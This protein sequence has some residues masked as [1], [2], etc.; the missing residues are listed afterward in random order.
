MFIQTK[1]LVNLE[2]Q[3]TI[4][5]VKNRLQ[6]IRH[7]V[8]FRLLKGLRKA[9]FFMLIADLLLRHGPL[10]LIRKIRSDISSTYT[11]HKNKATGIHIAGYLR[12]ILGTGEAARLFAGMIKNS[13]IPFTLINLPAGFHPRLSRKESLQ[14][15]FHLS[16]KIFF[17]T[18]L[19]FANANLLNDIFML[20]PEFK[21]SRRRA[22]VWWWEFEDGMD[23][24]I[25]GFK[26]INEVV[27][28][29]NFVKTAVEKILPE[30]K[31]VTKLL[32]PF[33]PEN[34]SNL[35]RGRILN[36]YDIGSDKFVFY[37]N[38][39]FASSIWRK[40]PV[41]ILS[42]FEK[43]FSRNDAVHLVFKTT[44]HTWFSDK[45]EFFSSSLSTHPLSK[46][47]TWIA[48]PVSRSE[49]NDLLRAID[50]F[51]SLHRGEGF[52]LGLLES[53]YIGKPVVA[54]N[55]GG[56]V[57][58]MKL[59]NSMLVNYSMRPCVDDYA[60]YRHVTRCAEPDIDHAA[61]CMRALYE[62]PEKG[63]ALGVRARQDILQQFDPQKCAEEY[64]TWIAGSL[65]K[66]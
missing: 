38:F 35:D 29:S 45:A 25:E 36:K 16:R 26:F 34:L 63:T 37:F 44:N 65:R 33:I 54:T 46:N 24:F 20:F 43:A 5:V 47:I 13:N 62:N 1:T 2:K 27:V 14:F 40:N 53:M 50:C 59:H 19:I 8:H 64:K 57:E 3:I 39:D 66:E 15:D 18:T 55:Y 22:A 4:P 41:G 17:D 58:F 49:H 48:K 31:N 10:F 11:N 6:Q 32:F 21:K 60:V 56:N 61:H 12:Q 9:G 7:A 52:G 30:D 23:D 28:F 42:A 51:V